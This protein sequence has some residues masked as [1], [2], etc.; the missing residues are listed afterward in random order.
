[1]EGPIVPRRTFALFALA[2]LVVV[3]SDMPGEASPAALARL[4]VD[5][6]S[7]AL[8]APDGQS[9]SVTVLASC[10][11]RWTVLQATVTVSQPQTSGKGSFPLTCIG[12]IRSFT[13]SVRSS[14]APFRLGQAQ[15]TGIVV[16]KRGRTER[17]RDSQVVDVDPAVFV[18]LAN[19]AKLQSGGQSVLIAVTAACPVGSV[20]QQSYVTVSQGQAR[21]TGFYEPICDG[22]GHIFNVRVPASQVLFRLG[23]AQALTFAFVEEGGDS[24]SGVDDQTIQIVSA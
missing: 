18:D 7:A 2:I 12:S 15:A 9:V 16:I 6:Q 5:V 4:T 10:P 19:N 22:K 24:F 21:G 3:G 17:V 14:G 8:L 20:G 11:E 1:M 13:V 23:S